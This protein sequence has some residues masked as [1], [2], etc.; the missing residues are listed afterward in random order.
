MNHRSVNKTPKSKILKTA[1]DLFSSKGYSETRMSEIAREAGLSVGALYLRFSSKEEL[2]LELI[3][4]Q[5]KGFDDL[6]KGLPEDP[7]KALR[8]YIALNIKY[9]FQKRQLIS[10]F[11]KEYNLA[12]LKPL[13]KK[14]FETQHG[15]IKDILVDGVKKRIFKPLNYEDT[16]LMVFAGIRGVV[17][18]KLIFGIGEIKTM[19]NALFRLITEGIRKD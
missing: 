8:D 10:M 2:C 19:S 15:I 12:F 5:T 11:F 18:L 1:L 7:L 17:L 14:F 16:S 3:K 6:T 13:R 4:D 9:A